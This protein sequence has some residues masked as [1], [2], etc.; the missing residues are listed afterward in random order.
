MIEN[1]GHQ[2]K[3]QRQACKKLTELS[4]PSGFIRELHFPF[5]QHLSFLLRALEERCVELFV[6]GLFNRGTR[7]R[8]SF[9]TSC[10]FLCHPSY[11][12][13]KQGMDGWLTDVSIFIL[14]LHNF[15]LFYLFWIMRK[16]KRWETKEMTKTAHLRPEDY[17]RKDEP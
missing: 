7:I 14:G 17:C 12:L 2:E 13:S 10:R 8:S 3:I 16:R 1:H 5:T 9:F 15:S 4:L 11:S 6:Y